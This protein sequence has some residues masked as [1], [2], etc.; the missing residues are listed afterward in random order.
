MSRSLDVLIVSQP[1]SYGVATCVL[2]LTE[3]AVA[4]GH[5]VTVACPGPDHGPLAGWIAGV[6]ARHEIR[7]MV[8]QPALRDLL[9]LW[10]IRRLARGRDVVHLHSSKAAALGRVAVT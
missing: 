5:R 7:N 1:V 2:Q 8:R 6:G 9:D 4:A 10:T 3:A